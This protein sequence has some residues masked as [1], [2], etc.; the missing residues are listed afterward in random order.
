GDLMWIGDNRRRAAGKDGTHKFSDTGHCAFNMNVGINKA[1]R[2]KTPADMHYLPGGIRAES[3]DKSIRNRNVAGM[4]FSRENIDYAR[5]GQKK[6]DRFF[7][8]R[9][10][11]HSI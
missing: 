4:D 3:D 1:R 11:D 9:E 7:A 5:I 8:A 6:I 2:N 10:L